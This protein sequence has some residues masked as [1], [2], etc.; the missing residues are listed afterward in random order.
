MEG[1][2]QYEYV[3]IP[4]KLS[5]TLDI[6]SG[7]SGVIDKIGLTTAGD[8][9]QVGDPVVFDN[10]GTQGSRASADVKKV[11]GKPL[12]QISVATSSVAG[13]EI[14]PSNQK[15]EYIIWSDKPHGFKNKDIIKVSGLSTTSSKIGGNY[16]VGIKSDTF[17]LI[18][19]GATPTGIGSDGVL[20][21]I[22]I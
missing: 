20:S 13:V 15:G 2:L 19:P 6:K 5:Q 4:D 3:Y 17:A 21:L 11:F 7:T 8:L 10:T 12:S 18:G 14:Y 1:S 9:Y 16:K 22:H